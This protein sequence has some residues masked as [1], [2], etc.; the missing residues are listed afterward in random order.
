MGSFNQVPSYK[1]IG[2][3]SHLA[4]DE[5]AAAA[6]AAEVGQPGEEGP[7]VANMRG[8]RRWQ[9]WFER[10]CVG[11]VGTGRGGG[12]CLWT[13]WVTGRCFTMQARQACQN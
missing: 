9:S 5:P 12:V 8:C 4:I 2:S 11:G 3:L 7:V 10:A 13:I 6:A 1:L